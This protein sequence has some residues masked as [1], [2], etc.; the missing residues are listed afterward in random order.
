MAFDVMEVPAVLH[1]SGEED[2]ASA[3]QEILSA[4]GD[5]SDWAP[6]DQWVLGATYIR[7]GKTRGGI[8]VPDQ[9]GG[10]SH[11]DQLLGK[12]FLLIAAGPLAF[13]HKLLG[14]WHGEAPATHTWFLARPGSGL[15]VSVQ[16]PGASNNNR[17]EQKGWPCRFFL[18]TDLIGPIPHPACIV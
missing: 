18:A 8:I 14:V 10:M 3:R 12:A 15:E 17:R 2:E 11:N 13:P 6:W 7:G 16:F 4:L 5:M 1:M 9:K